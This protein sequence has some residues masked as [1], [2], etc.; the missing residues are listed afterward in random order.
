MA[1]RWGKKWKQWKIFFLGSKITADGDCSHEIKRCLH[2]GSKGI[3]NLDSILKSRDISLLKNVYSQTYG[4]SSKHVLMWGLDHKERWVPK[5]WC[6]QIKV[7]E[8]TLES[9][10]ENKKIKSVNP[11]GNQPWTVIGK[12]DD[13]AEAPILW[14]TDVK[15]W[16]I[17]K[18]PDAG[19]DWRQKER[20]TAEDEMIGWHHWLNGDEFEQ[21]PGGG[22]RSEGWCAAVHGVTKSQTWLGD[23][24]TPWLAYG[25]HLPKS[26]HIPLSVFVCVIIS[27]Y[28]DTNPIGLTSTLMALL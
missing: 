5:N 27:S 20:G 10:S 23:W 6:F 9:L 22:G 24:T 8:K 19:K 18:D 3:T 17:G 1:N 13:E 11:K 16:L 21:T 15:N 12:T 2:L 25:R 26:S 28:K 7:L 4:F 14:S